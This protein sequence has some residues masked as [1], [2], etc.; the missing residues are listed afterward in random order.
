MG[1]YQEQLLTVKEAATKYGLSYWMIYNNIAHE[2]TFPAINL[3]PKRNYRIYE[4]GHK[5]LLTRRPA[6][7]KTKNRF[8]PSAD[9]ILEDLGL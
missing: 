4:G 9:D 5:D 1:I 2:P 7:A 3:G 6:S 8:V